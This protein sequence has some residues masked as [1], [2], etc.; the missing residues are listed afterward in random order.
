MGFKGKG[1]SQ[2]GDGRWGRVISFRSGDRRGE[3]QKARIVLVFL[4]T[5]WR[6]SRNICESARLRCKEAFLR[7][8]SAFPSLKDGVLPAASARQT[9]RLSPR[10]PQ[11]I[12]YIKQNS[13]HTRV[14][15]D[16]QRLTRRE[17]GSS[18]WTFFFLVLSTAAP[19]ATTSS[20][21]CPAA[22]SK[23]G[24]GLQFWGCLGR[25][26]ETSLR[27]LQPSRKRGDQ[28]YLVCTQRLHE[29]NAHLCVKGLR[30]GE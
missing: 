19:T 21:F 28:E 17:P 22:A 12:Y 26:A 6:P 9:R 30:H 2:L 18:S 25:I 16:L 15:A 24:F 13:N 20:A 27:L 5:R 4:W 3:L 7:A 1:S 23:G 14:P 29:R 10:G 11:A 8:P